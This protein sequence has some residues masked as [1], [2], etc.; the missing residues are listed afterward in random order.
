MQ[1]RNSNRITTLALQKFNKNTENAKGK[2]RQ[3]PQTMMY[4]KP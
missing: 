3:V 1:I 4:D 2:T